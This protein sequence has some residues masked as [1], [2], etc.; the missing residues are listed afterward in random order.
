MFK[1]FQTVFER[2]LEDFWIDNAHG[3]DVEKFDAEVVQ[4]GGCKLR[5][6]V[7]ARWGK[8]GVTVIKRLLPKRSARKRSA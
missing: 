7:K 5:G 2:S 4:S 6:A 3:L 1:R 8:D